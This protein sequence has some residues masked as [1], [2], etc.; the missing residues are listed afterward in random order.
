ML[1]G[2]RALD[3]RNQYWEGLKRLTAQE[4]IRRNKVLAVSYIVGRRA[5]ATSEDHVW[6]V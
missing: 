5:V 1:R 3:A 2:N 6:I 4:N